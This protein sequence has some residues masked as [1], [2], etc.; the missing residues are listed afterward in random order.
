MALAV[1]DQK[2][3]T[4]LL[5]FKRQN[6]DVDPD[7]PETQRQY[8]EMRLKFRR[9]SPHEFM[10][11]LDTNKDEVKAGS[12]STMVVWAVPKSNFPKGLP[13]KLKSAAIDPDE[14]NAPKDIDYDKFFVIDQCIPRD[15]LGKGVYTLS[16]FQACE[17]KFTTSGGGSS[18][19]R[20]LG[21]GAPL[22]GVLKMRGQSPS[23]S[24]K[25]HASSSNRILPM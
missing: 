5:G 11:Y 6:F 19:H 9:V 24:N 4:A 13:V 17:S 10:K 21:G 20:A 8:K 16:S 14:E 15:Q 12:K 18:S 2:T 22:S 1:T 7:D 25:D 23:P 3:R